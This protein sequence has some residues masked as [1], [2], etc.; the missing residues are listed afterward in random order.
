M[1][2]SEIT[3]PLCGGKGSER[4]SGEAKWCRVCQGSGVVVGFVCVN[5]EDDYISGADDERLG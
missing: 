1:P 2:A 5:P 4:I 3:C